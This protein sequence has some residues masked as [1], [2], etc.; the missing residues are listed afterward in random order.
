L[1]DNPAPAHGGAECTADG[2]SGLETGK[3]NE[4]P[5]PSTYTSNHF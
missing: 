3:C 5:C 2:S 4:N 1:C